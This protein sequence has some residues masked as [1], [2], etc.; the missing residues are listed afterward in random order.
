MWYKQTYQD[1]YDVLLKYSIIIFIS[2][3]AT[4][5]TF[6]MMYNAINFSNKKFWA[7]IHQSY[8]VLYGS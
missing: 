7:S 2:L 8:F 3:I 4:F 6:I 5:K 1:K